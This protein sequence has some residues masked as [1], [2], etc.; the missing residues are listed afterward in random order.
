MVLGTEDLDPDEFLRKDGRMK[1]IDCY[2]RDWLN[3]MQRTTAYTYEG[4][5]RTQSW[6]SASRFNASNDI[7][8]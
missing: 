3:H 8:S 7:A 5:V 6:K 4:A 2:G 1:S